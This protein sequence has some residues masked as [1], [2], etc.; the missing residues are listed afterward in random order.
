[1]ISFAMLQS[2]QPIGCRLQTSANLGDERNFAVP[3]FAT[4]LF[5]RVSALA[6][7]E[8]RVFDH[9]AVVRQVGGKIATRL[10]DLAARCARVLDQFFAQNRAW[11][12]P[13]ADAPAA[14]RVV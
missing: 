3:T 4:K 5:L 7:G 2:L 6:Q 11:G 9:P 10:S 12:M 13:G 8:E 1:M 14:A